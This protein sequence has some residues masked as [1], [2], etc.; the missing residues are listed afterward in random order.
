MHTLQLAAVSAILALLSYALILEN[1]WFS[2]AIY[3]I[4][5]C[6]LV[7]AADAAKGAFA[8]KRFIPFDALVRLAIFAPFLLLGHAC[9]RIV[10][11]SIPLTLSLRLG[12]KRLRDRLAS[13]TPPD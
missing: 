5:L 3:V 8:G 10:L 2:F 6:M 7:W 4:W 12:L 11:A 13:K 1:I 9:A